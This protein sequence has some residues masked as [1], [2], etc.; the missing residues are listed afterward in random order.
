MST[1]QKCPPGVVTAA[2]TSNSKSDFFLLQILPTARANNYVRVALCLLEELLEY[3]TYPVEHP[4]VPEI[5][6]EDVLSKGESD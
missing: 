4:R 1:Q 3:H 6:S 2:A 5:L